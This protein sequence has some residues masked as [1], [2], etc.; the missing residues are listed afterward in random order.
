MATQARGCPG[1]SSA[2]GTYSP[3][4]HANSM[5]MPLV[6]RARPGLIVPVEQEHEENERMKG[7]GECGEGQDSVREKVNHPLTE[8]THSRQDWTPCYQHGPRTNPR[9][10][11][12]G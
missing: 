8:P 4:P 11:G 5:A 3:S 12:R 7:R 9:A 1:P 6:K 10:H 2:D